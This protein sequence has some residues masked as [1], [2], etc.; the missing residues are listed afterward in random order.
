MPSSR[1][2][3]SGYIRF[4]LVTFPVK[5][6]T[7]ASSGGG[8][9]RLNQLHAKCNSRINYT[10]TCPQHGAVPA[11][12][13][14]SGYEFEKDQ[15]VVIDPEEIEKIRPKSEKDIA[16]AAF[17]EP[18]TIDASQFSGKS[19]YLLPDGPPAQRPYA[20]LMRAM[21]DQKRYAFAKIVMGGHDQIV[22]LRPMGKVLMMSWLSYASEMKDIA[23]FERDV[24]DVEVDP[25][26]LKLAKT[27]TDALAE[28]DFDI[29]Q[30][31]DTY[32][33]QLNKLIEA[34]VQGKEVVVPPDEPAPR[35]INLMEALQKSVSAAQK[36]GAKPAKVVAASPAAKAAQGASGRVRSAV[37]ATA[38][39]GY[40]V[41]TLNGVAA[42]EVCDR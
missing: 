23:E 7:A 27:L 16:V 35:I 34:K 39:R 15:Y 18:D 12:E 10:K 13:I 1:S 14:V 36:R 6:Y 21:K 5:A 9:V 26:E 41:L 11:N 8:G 28:D 2:V 19:Y 32:V 42:D 31:K 37:G 25:K 33:E 20:L 24:A 29:S 22:V 40:A 38:Q 30:Y 4:G 3:W 17:I